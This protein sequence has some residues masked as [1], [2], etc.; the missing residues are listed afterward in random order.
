[1]HSLFKGTVISVSHE[2][3]CVRDLDIE[4]GCES[5]LLYHIEL[6]CEAVI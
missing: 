3:E 4:A 5:V 2:K 6:M 1:M